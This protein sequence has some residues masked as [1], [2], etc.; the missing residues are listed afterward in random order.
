MTIH[1]VVNEAGSAGKTTTAVTLAAILAETGRRTLLW[2]NDPQGNATLFAGATAVPGKTAAEVLV[3][4]AA[5][6]EVLTPSAVDKLWVVPADR[7]LH[8]AT[9]QLTRGFGGEQKIRRAL[10]GLQDPFDAVVIDC[11]GAAG[12]LTIAA[13]VAARYVLAVAA[14]TLK[15]LE[16]LPNLERTLAEVNAAYNPHLELAAVIPCNVPPASAGTLYVEGL[17]QLRDAYGDL[18]T[19]PVRRSVRVP[20]AYSQRLPLTVHAPMEQ[21]TFDYQ[22]VFDSLVDRRILP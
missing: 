11:P 12:V 21:V 14:P 3:G 6:D 9:V 18:V 4:E 10:Q 19:P 8:G 22:A 7:S 20:E 17:N 1:A 13:L 16:G 15:E 5:L 2:D